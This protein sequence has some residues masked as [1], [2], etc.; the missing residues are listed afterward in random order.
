MAVFLHVEQNILF[1]ITRTYMVV[2]KYRRVNLF[3]Q[4]QRSKLLIIAPGLTPTP[5]HKYSILDLD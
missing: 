4:T 3:Q 5:T 2:T 1:I